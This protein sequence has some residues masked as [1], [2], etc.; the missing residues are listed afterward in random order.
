MARPERLAAHPLADASQHVSNQPQCDDRVRWRAGWVSDAGERSYGAGLSFGLVCAELREPPTIF[1][2]GGG[3]EAF[4]R[5][6]NLFYDLVEWGT[7]L[8]VNNSASG[9]KVAQQASVPRW[10]WGVAPP[11]QP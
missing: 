7:R 3:R 8:A 1:D 11:Y 4:E 6:L 10:G 2:W 5:W 9:A